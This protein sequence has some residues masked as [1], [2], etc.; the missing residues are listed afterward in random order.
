MA[1][2]ISN[3]L[4]RVWPKDI[5]K[6]AFIG[7]L[8]DA[9]KTTLLYK[10]KLGEIVITKP[11]IVFNVETVPL[12]TVSAS[13]SRP[14]TKLECWDAGGCRIL[15]LARYYTSGF[16][17]IVWMVD[18]SDRKRLKESVEALNIV[19][20]GM[21]LVKDIPI[22]ILANKQ[23][24]PN[25]MSVNDI[26]L[27]IKDTCKGRLW[28]VFPSTSFRTID[29]SGIPSA[30]DWLLS[31]VELSSPKYCATL[32]S[33]VPHPP[34]FPLRMNT[35][36]I[37][38]IFLGR[39]ESDSPPSV[40]LRQFHTYELPSWDHYTQIRLTY[41]LLH[42][43]GRQKAK[44]TIL[45]GFKNYIANSKETKG[46]S[47]HAT[48]TY[49]WMQVVHFGIQSMSKPPRQS[50]SHALG[51]SHAKFSS[52]N[53]SLPTI[54]D[55]DDDFIL[56]DD[57]ADQSTTSTL[58]ASL[59]DTGVDKTDLDFRSFLLLNPHVA[60]ENLWVDYYS[61]PVIM[62]WLARG[63]FVLPDKKNL[64]NLVARERVRVTS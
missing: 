48:M 55:C 37:F 24:L 42:V 23:D 36:N 64:P 27:Q 18:S 58:A 54:V 7:G 62:S 50:D 17:M 30:F 29:E 53:L 19:A 44:E 47:F 39:T 45:D 31:A 13:P 33:V 60:D 41:L 12:P 5:V 25:A 15:P 46:Y 57:D 20:N 2:I 34:N 10:L 11:T 1:S 63:G 16:D 26:L 38:Y 22:L 52:D 49:F 40:F 61:K 51:L 56:V 14:P 4:G 8:D 9:G 43:E 59:E 28:N 6:K 3:A 35:E 21:N 32:Q